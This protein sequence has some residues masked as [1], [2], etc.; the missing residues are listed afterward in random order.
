MKD[1]VFTTDTDENQAVLVGRCS[2]NST[3][4]LYTHSFGTILAIAATT[5]DKATG[6]VVYASDHFTCNI[7]QVLSSITTHANLQDVTNRVCGLRDRLTSLLS[8]CFYKAT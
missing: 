2:M 5:I 7:K 4:T 3:H 6:Y 1:A 8:N